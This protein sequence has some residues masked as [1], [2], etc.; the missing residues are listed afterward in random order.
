MNPE[1]EPSTTGALSVQTPISF[2]QERTFSWKGVNCQNVGRI[3]YDLQCFKKNIFLSQLDHPKIENKWASDSIEIC[4]LCRRTELKKK[5]FYFIFQVC[6]LISS[7]S[8]SMQRV[9]VLSNSE[10]LIARLA[11]GTK[12]SIR[13]SQQARFYKCLC[14]CVSFNCFG[15]AQWQLVRCFHEFCR[16]RMKDPASCVS[17]IEV[18]Q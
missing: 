12:E 11:F 4:Q 10:L 14:N 5:S 3:L 7:E 13:S 18:W 16:V 17:S 8:S 1:L 9:T 2:S 6:L 15:N